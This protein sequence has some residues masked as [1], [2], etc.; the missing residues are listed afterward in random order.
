MRCK[1]YFTRLK[2]DL[3]MESRICMKL[4]AEAELARQHNPMPLTDLC[5][6]SL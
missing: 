3:Y 4:V 1:I 2:S 5:G 6:L